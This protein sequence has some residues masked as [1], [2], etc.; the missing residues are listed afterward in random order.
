MSTERNV[1]VSDAERDVVAAQLREHFAQG[2]LSM[3]ELNERLDRVFASRTNLELA[4]VTNDLPYT[5]P[6]RVLPSDGVHNAGSGHGGGSGLWGG[7]YRGG[8]RPNGQGWQGQG[9]SGP[10]WNGTSWSGPGGRGHGRR[11]GSVLG[12]VPL[13]LAFVC[14]IILVSALG[15]GIGSGPSLIVIVLGALAVLRRLL[16]FGRRRGMPA[17]RR[18]GRRR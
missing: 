4:S 2:R 17:P 7:P 3:D 11:G 13:I 15:F 18:R 5:A 14:V 10:P 1:R 16:G 6:R 8:Q 9:W 12:F